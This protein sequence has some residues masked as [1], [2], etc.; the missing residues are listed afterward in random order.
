MAASAICLDSN[1]DAVSCNDADCTYGPCGEATTSNSQTGNSACLDASESPIACNDP[2][3]TYGDCIA[4]A[5]GASTGLAAAASSLS[6][7]GSNVAQSPLG[8]F[9]ALSTAAA[10]AYAATVTPT[11]VTTPATT[12]LSIGS[13]STL[14]LLA[15][16]VVVA[17]LVFGGKKKAT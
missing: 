11:R 8:I 5:P 4:T 9:S 17:F 14:L 6:G 12:G 13:N 10:S 2:S 16:A 15:G 1:Q 3:C 7:G